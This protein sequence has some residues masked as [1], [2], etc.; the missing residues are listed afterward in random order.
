M[1][2][3]SAGS[4]PLSPVAH[5]QSLYG[6]KHDARKAVA[7]LAKKFKYPIAVELGIEPEFGYDKPGRPKKT[8]EKTLKGY[9][10]SVELDEAQEAIAL[11]KVPLGRFVLATSKKGLMDRKC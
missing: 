3:F 4:S 6:C 7:T 5:A 11:A 9:H 8:D 1:P 10:I 2:Y